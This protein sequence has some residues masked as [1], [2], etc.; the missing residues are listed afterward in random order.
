MGVSRNNSLLQMKLY[1]AEGLADALRALGNDPLVKRLLKKALLEEGRPAAAE[2]RRL[3]P[4]APGGGKMADGIEISTT[5]SR[6]QTRGRRRR[7]RKDLEAEVFIGAAP[8]GPA[9]LN[10]FGTG[11]RYRKNGGFTGAMAA[12]PFMR[13]AWEKWK[14]RIL[15]RF[16]LRLWYEIAQAAERIRKKQERQL[17]REISEGRRRR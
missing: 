11:P 9:V 16:A 5:L 8:R 13:P 14:Y 17:K 2:A 15:D 4:K 7:N 12:T 1:G 3:A 6:R 10:E